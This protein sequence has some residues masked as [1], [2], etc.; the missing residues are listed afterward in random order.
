M[1]PVT[2]P[3]PWGSYTI[4]RDRADCKVKEI[5]VHP[6]HRLSLQSHTYR[7]EK[8]TVVSGTGRVTRNNERLTL[9]YG[10]SIE[11]AAG[12]KHRME[13][14]GTEELTFIEIQTGSYFGEDD[15]IRY[16]DDYNRT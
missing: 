12:Q 15:I 3:R 1:H 2:E 13:N 11:I 5:T 6:G 10:E 8:W 7:D 9:S 14:P 4:L 16:E